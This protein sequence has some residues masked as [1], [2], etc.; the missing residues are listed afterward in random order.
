MDDSIQLES[1]EIPIQGMSCDRC[2]ARVEAALRGIPGVE[3]VHAAIGRAR[4]EYQP[5]FVSR[6][7]IDRRIEELG[8]RIAAAGG[9]RRGGIRGWLDR[10]ARSNKASFGEAT[11]SCCT[12]GRKKAQDGGK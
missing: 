3:T 8:Y 10:M 2:V 7:E 1:T 6:I 4:V 11:L 9:Q 5:V 12:M